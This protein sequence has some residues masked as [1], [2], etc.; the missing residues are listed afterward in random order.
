M[1][2]IQI[3]ANSQLR[4]CL[5]FKDVNEAPIMAPGLS[6]LPLCKMTAKASTPS[7]FMASIGIVKFSLFPFQ[8]PSLTQRRTTLVYVRVRPRFSPRAMPTDTDALR[9]QSQTSPAPASA[10][11]RAGSL[12]ETRSLAT[13]TSSGTDRVD[14]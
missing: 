5:Q 13:F 11:W 8:L 3:K 14:G 6:K 7:N 12:T 9:A 2:R 10:R 1:P 4:E